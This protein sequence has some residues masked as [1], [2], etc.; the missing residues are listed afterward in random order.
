[1]VVESCR[2][3]GQGCVVVKSSAGT[4]WSAAS[5]LALVCFRLDDL[6]AG[7]R[8]TRLRDAEIDD[9]RPEQPVALFSPGVSL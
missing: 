1:M 6:V 2:R 9:E 3:M 5:T 7:G 4:E 8:E